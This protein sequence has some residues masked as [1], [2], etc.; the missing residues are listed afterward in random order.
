M[1]GKIFMSFASHNFWENRLIKTSFVTIHLP[2]STIRL[3]IY[4]L[5]SCFETIFLYLCIL[6]AACTIH[7]AIASC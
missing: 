3:E 4:Y 1:F 7:Y 6:K 5:S 2:L